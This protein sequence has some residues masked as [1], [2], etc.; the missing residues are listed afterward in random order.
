MT[1]RERLV[2]EG[3]LAPRGRLAD[4]PVDFAPADTA[5]LPIDGPWRAVARTTTADEFEALE[6]VQ[7]GRRRWL[8]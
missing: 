4:A 5:Y 2:A 1:L 3:L 6:A 7:G 8:A